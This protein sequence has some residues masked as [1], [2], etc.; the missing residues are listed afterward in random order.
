MVKDICHNNVLIGQVYDLNLVKGVGFPTSNRQS[1]QFGY[2]VINEDKDLEPH[3]HKRV[4]RT[5]Y[6]TSEF[7][8]VVKGLII[9]DVYN[10]DESY[11]ETVSLRNNQALL[12]Y[13]GGHKI[14]IQK[15]TKYFEIKQGP[16]YGHDFDKYALNKALN[17]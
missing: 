12:Q 8:Y 16:Y 5:I 6:T 13:L 11:V 4:K 10:E 9:I 3:I 1:F 15:G 17:E 2:G 7:L 14:T